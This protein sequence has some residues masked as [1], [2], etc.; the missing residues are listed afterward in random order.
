MGSP[1]TPNGDAEQIT[2]RTKKRPTLITQDW[3]LLL[4]A[5]MEGLLVNLLQVQ[6]RIQNRAQDSRCA[7]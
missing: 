1:L 3:T 6:D 7:V 5:G 4:F 2:S